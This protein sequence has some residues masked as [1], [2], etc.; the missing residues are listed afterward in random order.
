MSD[1]YADRSGNTQAF[2]AFV[3]REEPAPPARPTRL[4]VAGAVVLAVVI[5][6]AIV[7]LAAG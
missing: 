4:I 5:I 3:Q 7:W 2:Q 1:Q 6:G